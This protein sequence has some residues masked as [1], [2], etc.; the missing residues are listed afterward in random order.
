MTINIYKLIQNDPTFRLMGSFKD[1]VLKIDNKEIK[2]TEDEVL[3]RF[4]RGY[5]RISKI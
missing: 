3:N 2:M 4:S 5:W 1:G